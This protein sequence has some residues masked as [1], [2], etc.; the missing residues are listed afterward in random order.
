[1]EEDD[2]SNFD[3]ERALE[4]A[5]EYGNYDNLINYD[6]DE[7]YANDVVRESPTPIEGVSSTHIDGVSSTPMDD[8]STPGVGIIPEDQAG[9]IPP[10]PAEC[11]IP[12]RVPEMPGD[13]GTSV[14]AISIEP[15]V[16]G[17]AVPDHDRNS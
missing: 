15:P 3:F 6:N 5:L 16:E 14:P 11:L 1:M 10:P 7:T 9:Q 12:P 17:P 13:S 8:G 2:L 4:E